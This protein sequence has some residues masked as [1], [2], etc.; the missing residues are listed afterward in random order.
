[1]N[2]VARR[3]EPFVSGL[4]F[5]ECPRW[6]DGRLWYSDFY[7]STVSSADEEGDV[8]IEL[9]VPG[10][11]GGLG[12]LPDGRLLVVARKP[13]T[14][15]RWEHD[16]TLA[17]HADL[18]PAATYHAN[19]MVVCADGQAY[20]GNFGFDLDTFIEE[21][22]AHFFDPPRPPT[23]VLIRV[24]PDGTTAVAA[25]DI[26]FPNGTVIFPDG[27]TL[28]LAETLGGRLIAFDRGPDG[29]LTNRRIWAQIPRC[30]PD[31]GSERG[32]SRVPARRR[33]RRGRR[34][35]R[36]LA[37]LL[38]LHAGR[39]RPA[40]PLPHDRAHLDRVGGECQP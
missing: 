8:R 21:R 35:R 33:G 31:L 40:H 13:R 37:E 18:R 4:S 10:E 19:D 38:R 2:S 27:K 15:L 11:P 26:D 32:R 39:R 34:P 16:G 7:T 14:V 17:H 1:M 29:S 3:S 6:H 23:T 36:D 9:E 30:S 5:G 20:V 12:W 28:V 22:G 25:E 24:D